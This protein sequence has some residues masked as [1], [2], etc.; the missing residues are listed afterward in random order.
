MRRLALVAAV[1]VCGCSQ[2][3]QEAKS[4]KKAAPE[5]FRVDPLT[6]AAVKGRARFSGKLPAAKRIS[7]DA[8]EACQALHKT[9]VFED[10]VVVDKKG[11]LANVFVYIKGGFEGKTFAPASRNVVLE[12]KGCQFVPRVLAL[13]TGQTLTVKNSDPV[14]HNVHPTPRNNRDWNQQQAPQA[15]DLNRKFGYAEVM[16]PVKCNIH[17][18]MKSYIGVLDHP[19]FAVSDRAGQFAI[20]GLPAG[21]YVL[22]GWHESLG[23][24]TQRVTVKKGD[25]T[26]A[27]IV[28]Q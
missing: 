17:A 24:V 23:E 15:A 5:Y 1:L 9:P 14:S 3:K 10:K 7:M 21:E 25:A 4:E 13:R 22:A 26:P 18:W 2:P 16:I 12:Q 6:A 27:E 8:E 19:F 28:F 20:E 11:G